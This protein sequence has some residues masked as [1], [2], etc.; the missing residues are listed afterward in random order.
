LIFLDNKTKLTIPVTDRKKQKQNQ[1]QKHNNPGSSR[2]F[3]STG[4]K[5][6]WCE[7]KSRSGSLRHWFIDQQR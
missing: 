7:K 6:G 4:V 3:G 2:Y 5:L 1:K